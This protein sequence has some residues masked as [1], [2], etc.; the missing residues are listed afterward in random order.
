MVIIVDSDEKGEHRQRVIAQIE[1]CGVKTYVNNLWVG[2]YLCTDNPKVIVDRKK[3][4]EEL[5]HNLFNR[6]DKSRFWA[7]V[8]RANYLETKLIFLCE[9]GGNYRTIEDVANWKGKYSTVSGRDLMEKM[10]KVHISY[11]V[12]FLFCDKRNTGKRIVE[13]LGETVQ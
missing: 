12:D 5:A 10:Y 1:S 2:D 9:H 3:D 11:G 6:D 8:R 4:L 7:E 13:I